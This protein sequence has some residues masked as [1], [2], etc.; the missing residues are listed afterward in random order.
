MAE[1][2]G[3]STGGGVAL[4]EDVTGNYT[5]QPGDMGKVVNVTATATIT[6]PATLPGGW[7]CLVMADTGATVTISAGAGV[8]LRDPSTRATLSSNGACA[9]VFMRTRTEAVLI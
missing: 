3:I 8:T 6:I 7:N 5:L 4:Q 2:N 9:T 1:V